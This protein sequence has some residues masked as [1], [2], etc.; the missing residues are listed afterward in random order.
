ML[1]KQEHGGRLWPFTEASG[2]RLDGP[3]SQGQIARHRLQTDAQNSSLERR[4]KR[5]V[6]VSTSAP[7]MNPTTRAM[8]GERQSLSLL[9]SS[10]FLTIAA[11]WTHDEFSLAVSSLM[12]VDIHRCTRYRPNLA[13]SWYFAG[14][15]STPCF[16]TKFLRPPSVRR[17][18]YKN[19][20]LDF[21]ACSFSEKLDQSMRQIF[22]GRT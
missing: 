10:L 14:N 7:I 2:G 20:N 1:A 17:R 15:V 4:L 21:V 22:R 5:L 6:S 18:G 12:K 8:D 3:E 9:P 16:N 11:P 19:D 13:Q